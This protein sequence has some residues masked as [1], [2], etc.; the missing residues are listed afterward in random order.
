MDKLWEIYALKYTGRSNRTRAESFVTDDDP[1]ASHAI[2]CFIW[3]LRSGERLILVDTGYDEEEGT[4]RRRP[5]HRTPAA[6]LAAL[7]VAPEDIDTVIITHLHYDHAGGL[8]FFPNATF[9]LQSKELAW[10]NA[11][12]VCH[13]SLASPFTGRHIH[14]MMAL[15]RSGRVV[16]HQGD[17]EISDGVTVHLIGG[18]SRGLQAVRV[19]SEAGCIC[20]A[21][22]ATHYYENFIC[23]KPFPIY[24]DLQDMLDGFE[25]ICSLADDEKLV[26]P[27]HDPLMTN[28]FP[29]YGSSGFVWRLDGGLRP[30]REVLLP[31]RKAPCGIDSFQDAKRASG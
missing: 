24:A 26:V 13:D 7:N 28:L 23:A 22:D 11:P 17:G 1:T 21:S 8:H 10:A 18:H 4:R 31:P 27:G 14:D 9:H 15:V 3:L 19:R 30:G 29:A 2:D 12:G 20:L 6:A 5:I 25:S 16:L